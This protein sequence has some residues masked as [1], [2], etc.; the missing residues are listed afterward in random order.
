MKSG[1]VCAG[2][3]VGLGKFYVT[4]AIDY[5]NGEPHL[6][7]AYEKIAT[8]VIARYHRLAGDDT[9]FLTGTDEHS[10]NV[11]RRARE[12]G[13]SPKEFCDLMSE[14][15][16]QAWAKLEISYDR[17]IRTTD[18]DHV[19]TVQDLIRRIN[20]R[21]FIYQGTYSGWYCVS[22]E[23]FLDESELVEGHCPVHPSR[24]VEWVEERNYYFALSRFQE[25]LLHHIEEHPEFIQPETRRNEVLNRIREG[26]QDVSISRSTVEWGIPL[27]VDPQQVVYVWF[28]ALTNYVTGAGYGRRLLAH[29][30]QP[31]PQPQ[32]Q[33]QSQEH[34]FDYWWP[35][36]LHVVGKDITWF[37]CVIWS[38]ILLAAELPL[39]KTVFGHGFVNVGGAKLSKSEGVMVDPLQLADEYGA[40]VL[41]YYLT[42]EI[43]WGKDGDF[44]IGS[45][46]ER[47]N[48]DLANDLGNLLNRTVAMTDRFLA[49]TIQVPTGAGSAAQPPAASTPLDRSLIEHALRVV[50]EYQARMESL[51]LSGALDAVW[52]LVDMA[53]KYIDER[54]PWVLAR[55]SVTR[56]QLEEVMYNLAEVLRR[57]AIL[58][59]P[60]MPVAAEK[61]WTQLGLS[62]SPAQAPLG[63]LA[64]CHRWGVFPGGTKVQRGAPIFPRL[65]VAEPE[66]ATHPGQTAEP[67]AM[68]SAASTASATAGAAKVP[69]VTAKAGAAVP[70]TAPH[71]GVPPQ[72]T[73]K[74]GVQQG[75]VAAVKAAAGLSE[76]EAGLITIDQ[77]GEIRLRVARVLEAAKVEGADKLLRL[78]I[79]LGGEQRQIVAGIAKYYTPE[80]LVGKEIVVVANLKPAK[81]RGIVSQGML[82]AATSVDG[83][84]LALVTP[85]RPVGPGATVR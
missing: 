35:A 68:A 33:E 62:G 24:K 40:D 23:R 6:G 36:D 42:R 4:T 83:S 10:L 14:K 1:Y 26:L 70:A 39:P 7:H 73:G 32:V 52:S 21:G 17:F 41:R 27:P 28:D 82:L 9:F 25:R 49:G 63:G 57:I 66:A 45:L 58:I 81:L 47:Y 55:S 50:E 69:G 74:A 65:E 3:A 22:C 76:E 34:S 75:G 43:S 59:S 37:H 48:A 11:A 71:G 67:V 53:N 46:R 85:E 56:P 61:I 8:D 44:S 84:R 12:E 80:E 60:T 5:V 13:L 29:Q 30:S 79:D 64:S 16:R 20:D 31:Q 54:A 2:G 38:A 78:Q 18:E 15:F 72:E 19:A 77:F 51:D